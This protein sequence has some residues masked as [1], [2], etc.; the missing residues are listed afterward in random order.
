M[1]DDVLLAAVFVR[2]FQQVSDSGL[3][4]T[5]M[6]D[7]RVAVNHGI[8]RIRFEHACHHPHR[9]RLARTVLT[10]KAQHLALLEAE[11]QSGDGDV[12]AKRLI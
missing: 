3:R 7:D 6:G 4:A 2:E 12:V 9:R 5:A 10:E 1:Y 8:A 11:G